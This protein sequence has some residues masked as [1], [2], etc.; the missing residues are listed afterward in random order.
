M[1][2][3]I[4]TSRYKSIN[5]IIILSKKPDALLL[6]T[7]SLALSSIIGIAVCATLSTSCKST[8]GHVFA[9]LGL[10]MVSK[11]WEE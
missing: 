11:K 5:Q 1:S 6:G 4:K 3:Q 2:R 8:G 9:T 10:S 7:T